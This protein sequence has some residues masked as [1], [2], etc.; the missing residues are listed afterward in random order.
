MIVELADSRN[1]VFAL[2][3][4]ILKVSCPQVMQLTTNSSIPSMRHFENIIDI[5]IRYLN[6]RS[7][8]LSNGML[9]LVNWCFF[10]VKS[11]LIKCLPSRDAVDEQFQ[12][13]LDL[14][15]DNLIS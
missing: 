5:L 10:L 6:L 4:R 14:S 2:D 8:E 1:L 11:I 15:T 12:H 13:S 7:Q 3:K 9:N